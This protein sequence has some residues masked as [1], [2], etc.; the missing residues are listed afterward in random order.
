[1]AEQEWNFSDIEHHI[2]EL[3]QEHD[4]LNGILVEER[5]RIQM[6]SSDA[7]NG[8][9][10]EGWQTAERSW[11]E[12]ADAALEALNKVVAAIQS[13]HDSMTK[14]EGKLKGKFG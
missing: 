6:V 10:R 12:K 9:A 14:A 5:A 4:R 13:G 1:M 8:T 7:W 11:G 2:D 3:K